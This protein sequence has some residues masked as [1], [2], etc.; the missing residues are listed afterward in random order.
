MATL[1]ITHTVSGPM[2]KA[3]VPPRK[4]TWL[5]HCPRPFC[6]FCASAE[7]ESAAVQALATHM[8]HAHFPEHLKVERKGA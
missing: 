1:T 4:P 7:R 5:I 8:L 2:L 6:A 3:G